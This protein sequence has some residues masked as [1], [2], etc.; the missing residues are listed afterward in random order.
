MKT[1]ILT[2]SVLAFMASVAWAG[3]TTIPIV[4]SSGTTIV[5]KCCDANG[6]NCIYIVH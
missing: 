1:L 6:Q 5:Q 4:T 3:C 2:T